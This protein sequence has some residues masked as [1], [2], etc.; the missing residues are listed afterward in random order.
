MITASNHIEISDQ[1]NEIY[2]DK[3][4]LDLQFFKNHV[5]YIAEIKNI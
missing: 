2:I 1:K 3:E 5:E 4:I